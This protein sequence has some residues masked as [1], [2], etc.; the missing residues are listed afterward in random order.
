MAT[1]PLPILLLLLAFLF[2]Q[3][4]KQERANKPDAMAE[5]KISGAVSCVFPEGM[6]KADS[7]RY[8][9]GGG[10]DFQPTVMDSTPA[11]S[12]APAGMVWVPA[13]EFSMGGINPVGM[14]DGGHIPML[15]ARPVHRVKVKGFWMDVTEV[16][17]EQFAAFVKATGYVT[18]AEQK[19]TK[20]EFPGAPEE[21]L[22]PGSVVFTPTPGQVPLD[23]YYQ[24]WRYEPGASWRHPEGPGSSIEGREKYPVVHIAWQ[25]AAAYAKWAGKR[26]PTEAEWEF[27]ARGGKMGEMYA[28]GNQFKPD[29]K[30]MANTFQGTFP[31]HDQ[32]LDGFTGIA[33]VKQFSPNPFGL[34][35]IGGNVWEWCE[36]WYRYDYYQTLNAKGMAV[37]PQGPADSFDPAEP[38]VKKKVQRGGSF[39]C[40]DQYCT[41]YMV[42]TRGK[43]DWRSAS[44]H[45]GFRCVKDAPK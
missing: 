41:R 6:T 44:N 28:W 8:M 15:D 42:G 21:N 22:V 4:C 7:V 38:G 27:A 30:W 12:P 18:V 1:P 45:V 19:P 24:W 20:E 33:P 14:P 10:A 39:L 29:G 2:L 16:T 3:N 5:S 36:D 25:D 35:D 11:P 31:V 9:E 13:G 34:Y 43:G 32:G 23:N 37:N 26:L 17:N 40:T